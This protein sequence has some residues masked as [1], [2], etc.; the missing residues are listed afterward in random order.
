MVTGTN[1]LNLP[2]FHVPQ[3][4]LLQG[5][6]GVNRH[7]IANH[8]KLAAP[9][10]EAFNRVNPIDLSLDLGCVAIVAFG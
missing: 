9:I 10:I 2:L 4:M 7:A 8:R 1:K 5:R 3:L 6:L